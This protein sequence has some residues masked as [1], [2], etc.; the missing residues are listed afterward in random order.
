MVAVRS[1][2]ATGVLTNFGGRGAAEVGGRDPR[3]QRY[4]ERLVVRVEL[5]KDDPV[6]AVEQAVVGGEEDRGVVELAEVA[7]LADHAADPAVDAGQRGE[8]APPALAKRLDR[9]L[10]QQASEGDPGGLVVDRALVE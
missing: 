6:L 10:M 8:R 4:A 7:K 9:G 3:H 5:L 1:M 2:L